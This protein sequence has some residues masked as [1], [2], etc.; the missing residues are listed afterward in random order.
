M[1]IDKPLQAHL[2]HLEERLLQPAVRKSAKEMTELL[3]EDFI[4]VRSS[5]CIYHRK[6]IIEDLQHELPVQRSLTHFNTSVLAPGVV[7]ATYHATRYDSTEAPA[8]S[9][10]RSSIWK[11]IDGRW[12][13]IFHQGTPIREP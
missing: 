13:M 7:L 8:E 9:S 3:A 11:L 6:Q 4:E 2:Q 1:E 10:Q 5:G 12:R